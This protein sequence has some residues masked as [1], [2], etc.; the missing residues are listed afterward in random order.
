VHA[1]GYR[2]QKPRSLSWA[3]LEEGVAY[4]LV[5]LGRP[6]DQALT[7]LALMAEV[8]IQT[9]DV[10]TSEAASE[11]VIAEMVV[12]EAIENMEGSPTPAG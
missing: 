2:W 9:G 7:L 8:P 10:I 3:T 11:D 12:P 5:A 1:V 6:D 4:H